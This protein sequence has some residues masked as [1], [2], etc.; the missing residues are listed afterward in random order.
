MGWNCRGLS[1]ECDIRIGAISLRV[2][3][4]P[5]YHFQ[6]HQGHLTHLAAAHDKSVAGFL[7]ERINPCRGNG[8]LKAMQFDLLEQ[9][10]CR[11]HPVILA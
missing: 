7:A 8:H 11:V 5:A 4:R 1:R 9:N 2:F 10:M 3:Q 6:H